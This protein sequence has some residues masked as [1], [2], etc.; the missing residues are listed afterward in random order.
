MDREGEVY[1][2]FIPVDEELPFEPTNNIAN[3]LAIKRA[4]GWLKLNR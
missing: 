3:D 4:I 1:K 2:K